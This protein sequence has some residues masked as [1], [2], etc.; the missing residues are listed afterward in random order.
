VGWLLTALALS[1]GA[2]F[3]FDLFNKLVNMRHGM[4]KP[5]VKAEKDS[6]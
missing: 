6:K 4:G 5:E 3:W 1:L 2:P